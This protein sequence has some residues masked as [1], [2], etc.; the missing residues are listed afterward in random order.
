VMVGSGPAL[1]EAQALAASLGM[2][3]RVR[4]IPQTPTAQMPQYMNLFDE[5]VLPARI[6]PK[7]KEQFGR[8]LVEAMACRTPVVG[9][10][11]GGIPYV[12]GDA[13]L[14]YPERNVEALAASLRSLYEN[15]DLHQ[16]LQNAGRER[17]LQ[18]FTHRKVAEQIVQVYSR[19]LQREAPVAAA[20]G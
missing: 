2:A 4:W 11:T 5:L 9:S 17:Y 3:S 6:M 13:G 8:V 16:R 14:V 10:T 18:H 15:P 1:E 7:A 12:I 20:V 19:V